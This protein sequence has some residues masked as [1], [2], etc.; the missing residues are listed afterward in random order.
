[1]DPVIK[2][3]Y[4]AAVKGQSY[5]FATIIDSTAHGTPRKTGAKMVVLGDG[6]VVG[7][8]GGGKSEQEV[9]AKC[10]RA[11]KLDKPQI[12]EYRFSGAK[13]QPICG[14][15]VKVFIEPF[16]CQRNLIIC[17]AGHI[18]LPLSFLGKILH[19]SVIL[20]DDRPELANK[21]RFPHV[22][23]IF[24]SPHRVSLSRLS[25]EESSYVVILTQDHQRDFSCLQTVIDKPIKYIGVIGSLVKKQKFLADLRE[26]KVD[27]KHLMK[28][29][30]PVGLD[31]GAQTPEEIAV[32]IMAEIIQESHRDELKTLKFRKKLASK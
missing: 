29:K 23:H 5:A 25:L 30:M 4:E 18:A 24:C 3:A 7:T 14:G 26:V 21:K 31:L 16:S 32:S 2:A 20:I 12:V 8:I 22:D 6:T 10:L 1:M 13:G 11:I 19:F 27:K 9:S 15:L 17:G 28:L